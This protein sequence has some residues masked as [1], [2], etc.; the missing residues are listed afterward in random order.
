MTADSD[1]EAPVLVRVFAGAVG[2]VHPE[3]GA[4]VQLPAAVARDLVGR[5][6]AAPVTPD[7]RGLRD[8]A[9]RSRF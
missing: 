6:D 5:G 8:R 7:G 3:D 1:A 4:V 2:S 9:V